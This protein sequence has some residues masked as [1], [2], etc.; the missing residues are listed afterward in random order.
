ML[1]PKMVTRVRRNSFWER[2]EM[3]ERNITAERVRKEEERR[4]LFSSLIPRPHLAQGSRSTCSDVPR[5]DLME[6]RAI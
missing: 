5:L 6:P 4:R 2:E 1:G 3:W